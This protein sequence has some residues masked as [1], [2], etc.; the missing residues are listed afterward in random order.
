MVESWKQLEGQVVN[1][2][3]PLRRLLGGAEP[4]A[5][6]LTE[7]RGRSLAI[8]LLQTQPENAE[9]QLSQWKS[10]A[11][12]THPRLVRLF[13]MG[14]CQL[15]RQELL[16][17]LME[18]AEENLAEVLPQRPL[19]A[20]ETQDMLERAVE[21]MA[22]VHRKGFVH[23][24]L[25]PA[26]ILAVQDQLK[27][28]SD[29]LCRMDQAGSSPRTPGAYDPPEIASAGATAAGDVWSLGVTMVE[30]LTQRLPVWERAAWAE[31]VLP[32]TLPDP[33][34]EIARHCLQRNPRDRWSVAEIEARLRPPEPFK[35][36]RYV[37]PA[38]ALGLALV[39]IVAGLKLL[40][41]PPETGGAPSIPLEQPRK[42]SP[43]TKAAAADLKGVVQQVLPEVPQKA[44]DTIQ[45]RV[46]IRVRVTVDPS[47]K[48]VDAKLDSPAASQ[49]FA[50]LALRAARAWKFAP[51]EAANE[52]ILRFQFTRTATRVV[53][54][55]INR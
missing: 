8:K 24:H 42:V 47:G 12:L 40:K 22:Y 14:R 16:Y 49:Y 43:D 37:V 26:N 41:R 5:V 48:V 27:V 23:G 38:I 4:S 3:F 51:A 55:R 9:R 29:G 44:R 19:T 21:A 6:F 28:S 39:A 15:G 52:W 33:F 30:A 34:R 46:T 45:G 53:P 7:Q 11:S 10:A 54:T 25:K 20:A 36:R 35:K 13:D 50:K 2:E 31:P 18:Y 1:G 17:V 32:E